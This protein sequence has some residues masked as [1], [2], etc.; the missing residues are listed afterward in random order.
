MCYIS[1]KCNEIMGEKYFLWSMFNTPESAQRNEV[2]EMGWRQ[3]HAFEPCTKAA[4]PRTNG[5]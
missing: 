4:L 1:V 3:F 5:S 2:V